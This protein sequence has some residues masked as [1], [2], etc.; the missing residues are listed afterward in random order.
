VRFIYFAPVTWNSVGQRPHEFVEWLNERTSENIIWV[1]PNLLRFP[2]LSDLRKLHLHRGDPFKETPSWL[3]VVNVPA[4]PMEPL[5]ISRA[6]NRVFWKRALSSFFQDED[7][8]VVIGVPSKLAL[9]FSQR[10]AGRSRV[11]FDLMD[12][13]PAFQKGIAKKTI[14]ETQELLLATADFVTVSSSNLQKR[15]SGK[16]QEIELV[17]NGS[18]YHK[19][20]IKQAIGR[21]QGGEFTYSYVGT[22]GSWFDWDF[23]VNFARANPEVQIR[24]AGPVYTKPKQAT[25]ENVKLLGVLPN[26]E[27]AVEIRESDATLIPFKI[28]ELT[29]Y[30]D[31]IKFYDYAFFSKVVLS[32]CFGQMASRE[33]LK[34]VV[35]YPDS[36]KDFTFIHEQVSN[37]SREEQANNQSV[38]TTASW[39]ERF[40][41]SNL[42]ERFAIT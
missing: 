35:L 39:T 15:Y 10:V 22:I 9:W 7:L 32:S 28:N 6:I 1:E 20:G 3:R 4:I 23:V 12:Y 34:N 33:Q 21:P 24:L 26:H 17:L 13:F 19:M 2:K 18:S 41:G 11:L 25:P 31:P 27:A 16:C 8:G 37:L 29:Q 38:K 36:P 14:E 30:V 40:S 5:R 42:M